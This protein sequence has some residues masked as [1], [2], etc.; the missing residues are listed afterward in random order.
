MMTCDLSEHM[1]LTDSSRPLLKF[2]A[3]SA[4]TRTPFY[5]ASTDIVIFRIRE[6]EVEL[7]LRLQLV[8]D[9]Q[10]STQSEG[11]R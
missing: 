9:S 3:I 2:R 7:L 10:P 1:L 5:H 8:E 6:Q 4:L 11:M